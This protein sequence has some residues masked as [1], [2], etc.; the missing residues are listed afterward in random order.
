MLGVIDLPTYVIGVIAI[1]L[2]P[3]PNSMF[4]LTV[5]AQYRVQQVYTVADGVFIADFVFIFFSDLGAASLMIKYP[6]IFNIIKYVGGGYLAYLGMK[7]IIGAVKGWA[8]PVSDTVAE[9][10]LQSPNVFGRALILSL[11]NPKAILFFISFFVQFVDPSYPYPVVSFAV[12]AGILQVVSL[13]YLSV[14][15][16]SGAHLVRWFRSR[17]KIAAAGLASVG[18]LFM[19]FAIKL[20]TAT[21]A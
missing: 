8:K 18:A 20:W 6:A 9:P 17:H 3:G 12:L 4:C 13:T 7:M 10:S 2:L 15:I 11:L 21:I 19:S 5:G 16:F 14:L 1:I